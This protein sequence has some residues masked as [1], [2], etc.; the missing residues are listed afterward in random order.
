MS[1]VLLVTV[2]RSTQPIVTAIRELQQD[3]IIF[4]C[5][6]GSAGSESRTKGAGK[7]SRIVGSDGVAAS[8]PNIPTQ[9]GLDNRF[10]AARNLVQ[11]EE[12]E[13]LSECYLKISQQIRLLQQEFLR[14]FHCFLLKQ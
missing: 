4:L 3:R 13:G 6:M 8:L 7:P 2:S 1:K 5:S 14:V 11:I 10:Q 12:L 9:V